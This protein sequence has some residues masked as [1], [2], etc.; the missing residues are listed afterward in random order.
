MD[1]SVLDGKE[2][3][4]GVALVY[5]QYLSARDQTG[6]VIVTETFGGC[7]YDVWLG[8]CMEYMRTFPS[9]KKV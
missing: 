3:L 8:D 7:Q 5:P 6:E 4:S 2:G 9:L 1:S